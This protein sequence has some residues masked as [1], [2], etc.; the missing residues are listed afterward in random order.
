MEPAVQHVSS[1][2]WQ[3]VSS[4]VLPYRTVEIDDRIQFSKL[5]AITERVGGDPDDAPCVP[6]EDEIKVIVCT[7]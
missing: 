3:Q 7:G 5:E 2:V 6:V 4:S 1:S